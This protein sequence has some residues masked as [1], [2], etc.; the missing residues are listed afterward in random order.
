MINRQ[1]HEFHKAS[2]DKK[3][4]AQS[5]KSRLE[6][7]DY[8]LHYMQKEEKYNSKNNSIAYNPGAMIKA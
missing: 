6:H 8:G 7:L 4:D 3:Y 2:N 1:F 5:L